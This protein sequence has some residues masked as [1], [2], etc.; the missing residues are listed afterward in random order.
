MHE[1]NRNGTDESSDPDDTQSKGVGMT[2]RRML[3]AGATTWASVSLAGC[4]HYLTG[5]GDDG[6]KQTTTPEDGQGTNTTV[7]ANTTTTGSPGTGGD[8]TG[9]APTTTACQQSVKFLPGMEIGMLI[10]VFNSE[11]GSFA[12]TD[13]VDSVTVSF[14]DADIESKELE[15]SGS[16]ESHSEESWGGTVETSADTE[17][18]TYR[19]EVTVEPKPDADIDGVTITDQFTIV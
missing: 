18:G 16:H 7:T 13:A 11:D 4:V 12:G 5:P 9:G 3:A 8:S 6:G 19:Y 17:P 2:R 14:P 15:W 10:D 1:D